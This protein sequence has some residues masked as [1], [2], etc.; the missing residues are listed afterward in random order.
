[1]MGQGHCWR[2]FGL[3]SQPSYKPHQQNLFKGC[4]VMK[5]YMPL[6]PIKKGYKMWWLCDST[7]GYMY[8]MSLYTG[9]GDS[10]NDDSLSPVMV[11]HLLHPLYHANH[12]V[13]MDNHLSNIAL[14]SK[15]TENNTYT[16]GIVRSNRKHCRAE[17]ENIKVIVHCVERQ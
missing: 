2:G 12:H 10:S 14:A 4:S 16:I 8:N 9:G 17:Y 7:N 3:N 1:M 13:Y 15:L 5:Q 11:Q 6:K